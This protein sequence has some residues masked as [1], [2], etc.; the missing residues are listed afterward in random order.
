MHGTTPELLCCLRRQ[1]PLERHAGGE[2]SSKN[3]VALV[4]SL[5]SQFLPLRGRNGHYGGSVWYTFSMGKVI[6]GL[7]EKHGCLSNFKLSGDF[8]GEEY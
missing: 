8:D 4:M 1:R 5:H 3:K 2:I 7:K 6:K